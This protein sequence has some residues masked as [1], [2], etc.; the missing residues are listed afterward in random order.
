MT[1]S[2]FTT[3][4]N[5]TISLPPRR[6]ILQGTTSHTLT[7][8][9]LNELRTFLNRTHHAS[10]APE[11]LN[12]MTSHY[13]LHHHILNKN[14][15]FISLTNTSSRKNRQEIFL[16]SLDI[17][18]MEPSSLIYQE[19]T[20]DRLGRDA[21]NN[22]STTSNGPS[23]NKTAKRTVETNPSTSAAD[24]FTHDPSLDTHMETASSF[25]FIIHKQALPSLPNPRDK[26]SPNFAAFDH[27]DHYHFIYTIAQSNNA[28][29]TLTN[30][31]QYL[32]VSFQGT[33]EAHTKAQPIRFFDR[34]L[35]YLV[36][37]GLRTFHKY[38][39]NPLAILRKI[40]EYLII[41][42]TNLTAPLNTAPFTPRRKNP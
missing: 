21:S 24:R 40:T 41:I 5:R 38:G 11:P 7:E 34:F 42:P 25:T 35:A 39:T 31:L 14:L 20:N 33:A 8:E 22:K 30:I 12:K 26:R 15:L 37:K 19:Q 32:K 18:R 2:T 29:R 28:A 10:S 13:Q 9:I 36:R 17:L 16:R 3:P 4:Q 1:W 27:G 23:R 6:Y